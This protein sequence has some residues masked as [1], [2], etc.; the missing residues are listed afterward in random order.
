M[1]NLLILIL[2]LLVTN[3]CVAS[4][5]KYIEKKKVDLDRNGS[6]ET[7]V[8]TIDKNTHFLEEDSNLDGISDICTTRKT[9]GITTTITTDIK[10]DNT[11]ETKSISID[12]QTFTDSIDSNSDGKFDNERKFLKSKLVDS[13]DTNYD[14]I[15]DVVHTTQMIDN[16]MLGKCEIDTDYDGSI[17]KSF[18]SKWN[19]D[20]NDCIIWIGNNKPNYTINKAKISKSLQL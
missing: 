8:Y 14:G 2:G 5:D 17:D 16:V 20:Y 12:G 6:L 3:V 19:G 4:P 11:I 15:M 9:E 7:T 1:K 10:C 18:E 13:Y